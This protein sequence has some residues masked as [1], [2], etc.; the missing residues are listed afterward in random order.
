[1]KNFTECVGEYKM[2]RQMNNEKMN[3]EMGC[4]RFKL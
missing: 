3:N 2:R 4:G 1:M